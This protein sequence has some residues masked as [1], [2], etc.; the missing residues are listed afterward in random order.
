MASDG[1][2]CFCNYFYMPASDSYEIKVE[3]RRPDVAL[4]SRTRFHY[5]P[6]RPS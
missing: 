5:E 3:I 2:V 6:H 1:A 4:V